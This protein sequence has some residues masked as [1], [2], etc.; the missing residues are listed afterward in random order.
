MLHTSRVSVVRRLAT[1]LVRAHHRLADS[2]QSSV[3]RYRRMKEAMSQLVP[4]AHSSLINSPRFELRYRPRPSTFGAASRASVLGRA[5]LCA[6]AGPWDG[7]RPRRPCSP[8]VSTV[9]PVTPRY[10]CVHRPLAIGSDTHLNLAYHTSYPT[11]CC[12]MR[13]RVAARP[14]TASARTPGR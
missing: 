11:R 6:T 5:H 13:R 3:V 14:S 7:R 9:I 4:R 2:A 12:V 10:T 1:H 8:A